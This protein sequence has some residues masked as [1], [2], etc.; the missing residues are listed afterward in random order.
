MHPLMDRESG[1]AGTASGKSGSLPDVKAGVSSAVGR[2][3]P[4]Y[5]SLLHRSGETSVFCLTDVRLRA[6]R[7]SYFRRVTDRLTDP[8]SNPRQVCQTRRITKKVRR[9]AVQL[10]FP[11]VKPYKIISVKS[12]RSPLS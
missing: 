3:N 2:T 11:T 12:R 6:E 4:F 9:P 10:Y 5:R 8:R 1:T 7:T